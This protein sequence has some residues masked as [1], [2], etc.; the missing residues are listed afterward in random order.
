M[1]MTVQHGLCACTL[2]AVLHAMIHL[3]LLQCA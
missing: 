1:L 2:H 3:S